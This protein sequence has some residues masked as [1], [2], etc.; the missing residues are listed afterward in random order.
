MN[1]DQWRGPNKNGSVEIWNPPIEWS[2]EKSI[3]GKAV[4]P[5]KGSSTPIIHDN[6]VI[7]LSV[8][9]TDRG[10]SHLFCIGG[11]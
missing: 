5:G 2:L 9:K 10:E 11:K 3:V 7:V 6:Q 8:L 4:L 1:W